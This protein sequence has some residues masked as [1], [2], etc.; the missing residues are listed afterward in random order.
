MYAII[1]TGGKQAKVREGDV[2]DVEKINADGDEI[3]F[4]PLLL[5][6]A[7][8]KITSGRDHLKDAKVTAKV[9]G[10]SAGDKIDMFKY[11]NKTGYRRRGGHRQKYTT[12]E[13]TKIEGPKKAAA[14]KAAEPASGEEG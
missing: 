11:K 1:R 13:V 7:K 8:G 4:T 2:I 6:D 3:T 14:K 12:I 5:V 10:E 9:V